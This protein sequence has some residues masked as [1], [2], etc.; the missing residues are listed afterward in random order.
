MLAHERVEIQ[1]SA[2]SRHGE[3]EL[4]LCPGLC[5]V[6]ARGTWLLG[7]RSVSLGSCLEGVGLLGPEPLLASDRG[8]QARGTVPARPETK[9]LLS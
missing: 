4:R 1:G 9:P 6:F 7:S 2:G 5:G 8:A 3:L